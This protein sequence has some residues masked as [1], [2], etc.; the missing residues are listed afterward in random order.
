MLWVV[1]GTGIA[2]LLAAIATLRSAKDGTS[3]PWRLVR[4]FAGFIC[5]MVWIAAIADEVVSVLQV[6]EDHG[7]RDNADN[8][9]VGEIL[10]LSDAIIG[11]TSEFAIAKSRYHAECSLRCGQQSGGPRGER[12]GCAIRA[13]HGLRRVLC[14]S[15]W[16]PSSVRY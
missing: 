2:G 15:R 4:C 5:S 10:G 7:R 16:R 12:D 11:L 13:G 9:A 14:E 6:S 3:R 1:L 8:Q